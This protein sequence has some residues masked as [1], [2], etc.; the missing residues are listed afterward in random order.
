LPDW[1]FRGDL[2]DQYKFLD[3]VQTRDNFLAKQTSESLLGFEL[4]DAVEI[5]HSEFTNAHDVYLQASNVTFHHNWI[6]NL[7]DDGLLLDGSAIA[8][9]LV[10]HNVIVRTLSAIGFAGDYLAGKWQ[11][12]RN[13]VDLRQPTAGF[14]PRNTSSD[15]SHVWRIGAAFKGG[16][17]PE[18]PYD[19]FQNTFISPFGAEYPAGLPEYPQASFTHLRNSVAPLSQRR[20]INNVFAVL[21]REPALDAPFA[22]L[23]PPGAPAAINGDLFYKKGYGTQVFMTPIPGDPEHFHLFSCAPGQ[24]CLNSWH[25]NA[26]FQSTQASNP[27]GYEANAVLMLDP[28]FH[29]WTGETSTADDFRLK[30]TSPGR[31]AGV[32]LPVDLQK[33]DLETSGTGAPDIGAYQASADTGLA[34][35]LRVGVGGRKVYPESGPGY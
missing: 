14:R 31:N 12:Y 24:N 11:I 35:K 2:K 10:H 5:S 13:L 27:P 9:G 7:H 32:L 33:L 30:R 19:I 6:S 26:F 25:A 16:R 23:L 21:N 29:S 8:S 28:E 17:T 1:L 18:G 4:T 34:P 15:R 3:G 22:F 20:S